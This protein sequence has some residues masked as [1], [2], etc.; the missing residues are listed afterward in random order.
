VYGIDSGDPLTFVAATAILLLVGLVA[1]Y[2][3]T[4]RATRLNPVD[5]IRSE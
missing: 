3:P 5:A 4:R 1:S 2:L